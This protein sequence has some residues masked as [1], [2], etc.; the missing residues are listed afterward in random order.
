MTRSGHESHA[1]SAN[2]AWRGR[3]RAHRGLV[4][5]LVAVSAAVLPAAASFV[6]Q[7]G[8]PLFGGV[9]EAACKYNLTNM[10]T[11]NGYGWAKVVTDWCYSGGHVTSRHSEKH[12]QISGWGYSIGYSGCRTTWRYSNCHNYNGYWNHNCLTRAEVF[13]YG[14]RYE[15]ACIHTRIYGNGDHRRL[16]TDGYCP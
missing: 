2:T 10:H 9:A 1:R 13:A 7:G 12:C 5:G 15:I 16:I 11:Q 6:P 4:I 14:H 3:S 8:N